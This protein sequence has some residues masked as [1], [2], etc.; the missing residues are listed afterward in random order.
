MTTPAKL[1]AMPLWADFDDQTV[2][3]NRMCN[4]DMFEDHFLRALSQLQVDGNT[5]ARL[6]HYCV[7]PW[8]SGAPF[9]IGMFERVLDHVLALGEVWTP[10]AAEVAAAWKAMR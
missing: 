3:V 8:V 2:L 1:V 6:F 4:L 7:R 10:T 5:T 9:R